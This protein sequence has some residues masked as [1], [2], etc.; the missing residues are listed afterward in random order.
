MGSLGAMTPI[1]ALTRRQVT[2]EALW[3][4]LMHRFL[5]DVQPL[6]VCRRP[7]P[8]VFGLR[9]PNIVMSN[10]ANKHVSATAVVTIVC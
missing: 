4:N 6:Q 7:R 2:P 9:L 3:C 5:A 10:P 8:T 1:F